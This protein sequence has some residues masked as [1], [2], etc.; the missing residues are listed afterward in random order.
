VPVRI[1]LKRC[2]SNVLSFLRLGCSVEIASLHIFVGLLS[3]HISSNCTEHSSCPDQQV[4]FVTIAQTLRQFDGPLFSRG[5]A[6]DACRARGL[7]RQ[8]LFRSAPGIINLA[9]N[10]YEVLC[11]AGQKCVAIRCMLWENVKSGRH[12]RGLNSLTVRS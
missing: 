6:K 12:A 7:T 9:L 1:D 3:T 5:V 2:S 10:V 11:I 4:A 8:V